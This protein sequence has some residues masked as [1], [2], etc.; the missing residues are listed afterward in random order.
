MK[1]SYKHM[2]D[3]FDYTDAVRKAAQVEESL[4]SIYNPDNEVEELRDSLRALTGMP[5]EILMGRVT[6]QDGMLRASIGVR[7]PNIGTRAGRH[8]FSIGQKF[9]IDIS[10]LEKL[11]CV[12]YIDEWPDKGSRWNIFDVVEMVEERSFKFVGEMDTLLNLKR[13]GG[14]W[15]ESLFAAH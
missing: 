3:S 5:F 9:I 1:K 6:C 10:K 14:S 15:Y 12:R 2:L 13:N 11:F 8:A 7:D 4:G